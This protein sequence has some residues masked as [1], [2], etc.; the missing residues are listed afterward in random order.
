MDA[1]R[2]CCA[3]L[4]VHQANVV[5]CLLK[6]SLD[7]KP[8]KQIREFP[9]VLSGLLALADWLEQEGC[10]DIAMEST[11][12]YWRPIYNV[13]EATCNITV[14]N[15]GHIKN[16]KGRKT[17][18]KDAQ[19]IAELH[20]CDLIRSSFI[21]PR[22]IR[23]LRDFTRYRK[24]LKGYQSAERNRI[25]KVLEDANI[26]VST[27]M[28]DV[29]G[30]SGRLMLEAL[31]N[32]EVIEPSQ[33][34]DLAKGKLRAKIPELVQALNGRITKH[35]RNIIQKSLNHL[36]FLE[37]AIADVEAD[38]EQYFTPY[39]DQLELLQTIPG[40]GPHT[41]KVIVAEIGVDMSVFP[42]AAHISSWA[43]LSPGNNESAGKKKLQPQPKEMPLSDRV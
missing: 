36:K 12:I 14:A 24:K 23:E 11:G 20:R 41:A 7:R 10:T 4:D 27:Y 5:V 6:G 35:H 39:Q 3:G 16:I 40:V 26:K 9:T 38:M 22:E 28:S 43:G 33:V 15:A 32:G 21:P 8:E 25:L 30:V 29:F 18:I 17:D 1:I 37:Q 13:L 42:T 2:T 19:W 31:V 34:A